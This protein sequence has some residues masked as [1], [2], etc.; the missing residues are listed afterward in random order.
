MLHFRRAAHQWAATRPVH[1]EKVDRIDHIEFHVPWPDVG[2]VRL[3]KDVHDLQG[4]VPAGLRAQL[5]TLDD[6][7]PDSLPRRLWLSG[8]KS[9]RPSPAALAAWHERALLLVA[10]S[11]ALP[12]E[13][14]DDLWA[15]VV[16][17]PVLKLCLEDDAEDR[18]GIEPLYD[19]PDLMEDDDTYELTPGLPLSTGTGPAPM[20]VDD[21]DETS[22]QSTYLAGDDAAP[23]PAPSA[24][25]A[26]TAVSEPEPQEVA[27]IMAGPDDPEAY[28]VALCVAG[29][30]PGLD[31]TPGEDHLT[32]L[33]PSVG[34]TDSLVDEE[35]GQPLQL[36]AYA[37]VSQ[38]PRVLAGLATT[39]LWIDGHDATRPLRELAPGGFLACRP[40]GSLVIR[41]TPGDDA[42]AV[43][44]DMARWV[45]AW[46][47]HL[48]MYT[49]MS[50]DLNRPIITVP[51]L[52]V[53]RD[54]WSVMFVVDTGPKTGLTA[55]STSLTLRWS[56][57]TPAASW[58]ST[59]CAA[60]CKSL[61]AGW[62]WA[63][64]P[65]RAASSASASALLRTM[66]SRRR[67]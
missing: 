3:L 65:G 27:I 43:R 36:V 39:A 45:S 17:T 53:N 23:S 42:E 50:I 37:L 61:P 51:I 26:M 13:A 63:L 47:E 33:A 34:F 32:Y 54:E 24:S 9:E 56:S 28:A 31:H 46:Y 4:V 11:S 30:G 21:D 20:V 41:K 38:E 57:A 48:L 44:L 49:G 8:P 58:A 60:P 52:R 22:S 35:T 40:P 12:Y 18:I 1:R 19:H 6:E 67:S 66:P 16:H 15:A 29:P 7:D 25:T 2:L 62:K 14:A 55:S 59:S 5:V 10:E 64:S